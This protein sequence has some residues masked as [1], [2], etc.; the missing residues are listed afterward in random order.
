LIDILIDTDPGIDDLLAVLMAL[1]SDVLLVKALLSTCGNVGV[2]RTT[3]NLLSIAALAGRADIPVYRGAER[4]LTGDL[5]SATHVHGED[6]L[7][8]VTLPEP[9]AEPAGTALERLVREY[10]DVSETVLVC[11]GP[12]TN[13]AAALTE[14]PSI[15][16][17]IP[18]VVAMGGG[19]SGGN[20]TM[21]AEFNVWCDP[22]AAAAVF[23][24]GIPVTLIPL[25][26][27]RRTRVT[28]DW[29]STIRALPR[30]GGL[31]AAAVEQY[32]GSGALHDPNTIAWLENPDL[33]ST[34]TGHVTVTIEGEEAGRTHFAHGHGLHSVAFDVDP[35]AFF[36]ALTNRLNRVATVRHR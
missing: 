3:R 14:Q 27:T 35:A 13:L 5:V 34:R 18:H 7:G 26:A 16:A 25:D 32:R 2:D 19:F 20:V 8:G 33:Y 4:P 6:G 29:L 12:M 21:Q 11:L 24:S 22:A 9:E 17:H 15:A 31:L 10:Q 30:I 28:P 1:G 23:S 36:N